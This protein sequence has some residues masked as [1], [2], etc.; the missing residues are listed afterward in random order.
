M[1][2][3]L[4]VMVL[5]Q[6]KLAPERHDGVPLGRG[7]SLATVTL[8][9]PTGGWSVGRMLKVEGRVSDTSIDPVTVSI[10]GDRYLMR[11]RAGAFSREFPAA[12]GK[13]VVTVLA[14][15]QAGT[16]RAQATTFAQIPPVP[17]KVVLTSDTD[18]VYTDLHLYEPTDTSEAGG[19]LDAAKMAHV[20]WAN[21]SSPSGG[22]FFLNEQAGDYDQPGYGPYLYVHRAPPKGTYLIAANYWPSGDKAHTLAT[23]NIS[24]FEGTP[25]EIRKTVKIPLATP[26]STRVLAW[27]Y[28]LGGGR[29]LVYVPT[30]D[31]K[32][33]DERWPKNLDAAAKAMQSEGGGGGEGF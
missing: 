7:T 4:L 11:T 26:G 24:L 25:N 17:M 28:V 23:L 10:N 18:G 21:T 22:T 29:A 9:K 30:A 13:N 32:P 2:Q 14:T 19:E 16:A 15:N 6:A 20:F 31:P 27:V 12:T 1:V 3:V 5:S 8:T 33:T